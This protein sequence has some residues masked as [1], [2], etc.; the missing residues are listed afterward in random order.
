M[1][2]RN[3]NQISLISLL[4]HI[5]Y[6]YKNKHYSVHD[7]LTSIMDRVTHM[8][9]PIEMV[10]AIIGISAEIRGWIMLLKKKKKE[11]TKPPSLFNSSFGIT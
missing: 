2:N 7:V 1:K 9:E 6:H 10:F 5:F 3:L 11:D 8:T 4:E